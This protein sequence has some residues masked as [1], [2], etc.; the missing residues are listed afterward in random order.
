MSKEK[1]WDYVLS[2]Q[3]FL[4]VAEFLD[5]LDA[6]LLPILLE[7]LENL[8]TKYPEK[9]HRVTVERHVFTLSRLRVIIEFSIWYYASRSAIRWNL[10]VAP[11]P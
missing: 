8:L 4:F 3:S 6:E 11:S 9:V 10:V 2:E 5:R 1:M 7:L